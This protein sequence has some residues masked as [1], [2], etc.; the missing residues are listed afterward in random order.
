MPH[1]LLQCPLF[2]AAR[3]GDWR[4]YVE[5][6]ALRRPSLPRRVLQNPTHYPISAS[7]RVG[8][9]IVGPWAAASYFSFLSI[10]G[11]AWA[12]SDVP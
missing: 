1:H 6:C 8:L 12:W 3:S 2:N 10:E 11:H 9:F 5:V 4:F 7:F